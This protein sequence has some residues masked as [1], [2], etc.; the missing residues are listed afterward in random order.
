MKKVVLFDLD[1]T[2]TDSSEGIINS[3]RYM[4]EKLSLEIP[5]KATLF[6][7]IGPPLDESLSRLYGL[8]DSES[9]KAVEIYREYYS[10]QGIHQL[11]VYAGIAE[12]LEELFPD[13]VLAVA[14]SKP[15]FFAKQIIESAGLMQYF[16]GVFGADL[17][18]ERS[19]KTDVI[20]Y[21][22]KELGEDSGVMVGDRK[23]DISGAKANQLKSIGV[24]FGFGDREEMIDAKADQIVAT[25]AELSAAIKNSF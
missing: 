25:V 5:D 11:R 17:A 18:G 10:D 15:E 21:A 14:T 7:F 1:G 4:L 8:T 13:Y 3:V 12:M 20:A 24:L 16:S 6:S 23:F 22:L 19:N 2:L 9:K